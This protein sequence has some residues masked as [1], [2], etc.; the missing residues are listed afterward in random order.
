MFKSLLDLNSADGIP[1]NTF[2]K[3]FILCRGCDHVLTGD[4]VDESYRIK[5][6]IE[7]GTQ[8]MSII[9]LLPNPNFGLFLNLRHLSAQPPKNMYSELR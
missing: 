8:K 2:W 4:V 6:S 1:A 5:L 3:M 7:R 9:T